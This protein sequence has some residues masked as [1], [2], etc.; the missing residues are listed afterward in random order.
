[1]NT[2]QR[3]LSKGLKSQKKESILMIKM[4]PAAKTHSNENWSV[5]FSKSECEVIF[6][7]KYLNIRIVWEINYRCSLRTFDPLAL[8][9]WHV[10]MRKC[11]KYYIFCLTNNYTACI[12][13]TIVLVAVLFLHIFIMHCAKKASC[14]N[15]FS[16]QDLLVTCW[17]NQR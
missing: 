7:N 5:L 11:K 4:P 10:K 3:K 2:F 15:M 8:K 17:W 6:T 14:S 13:W 12:F 9:C 16:P 1:M